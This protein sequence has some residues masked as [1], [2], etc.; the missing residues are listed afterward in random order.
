MM[1]VFY[2]AVSYIKSQIYH[3]YKKCV[4]LSA[5]V[6]PGE[7]PGSWVMEGI[8]RYL[9]SNE[10]HNLRKEYIFIIVPMLNPDGVRYGNYR[11]SLV[12]HDL[13]RKWVSPNRYL[14]PEIYYFKNLIKVFQ[15]EREIC[16]FCDMHGH[17]RKH[18]VFMYGC[19]YKPNEHDFIRKN[20]QIRIIPLML[21]QRNAFFSYKDSQFGLDKEKETTAR[22]VLF[23]EFDIKYSFTCEATFFGTINPFTKEIQ[24]MKIQDYKEVGKD[25]CVTI[26]CLSN[27]AYT[28]KYLNVM[29]T[30][31]R[32]RFYQNALANKIEPPLL[33]KPENGSIDGNKSK[34]LQQ[35]ID[36]ESALEND[37]D[38]PN[39]NDIS[40]TDS[41]DNLKM[42]LKETKTY[43][44]IRSLSLKKK[45]TK[46]K[47]RKETPDNYSPAYP[48]VSPSITR[49]TMYYPAHSQTRSYNRPHNK[50]KKSMELINNDIDKECS[51]D[52]T[53]LK[54][55]KQPLYRL[56]LTSTMPKNKVEDNLT[57]FNQIPT[58]ISKN[59]RIKCMGM[60]SMA[61]IAEEKACNDIYIGKNTLFKAKKS[62]INREHFCKNRDNIKLSVVGKK[63]LQTPILIE[64]EKLHASNRPLNQL[65]RREE[66]LSHDVM[67]KQFLGLLIPK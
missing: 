53:P 62:N 15:H 59:S 41:E 3:K 1:K 26:S 45:L 13:N 19:S 8:I 52:D 35:L 33:N 67:Y 7:V 22:I 57:N 50:L 27:N 30:Y 60:R 34:L 58:F 39:A 61:T 46:K 38:D 18:N 40:S 54:V 20:S 56:R 11:C 32:E 10:A 9:L 51:G 23:R 25:L 6:H 29:N 12:G 49:N 44:K 17:F 4:F 21:S 47:V 5:R 36:S 31:L 37:N 66:I 65:I 14:H 64:Y 63:K 48:E 16:M 55:K 24:T 42:L 28:E 2:Y 43:Q